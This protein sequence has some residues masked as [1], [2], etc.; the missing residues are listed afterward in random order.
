MP[1]QPTAAAACSSQTAGFREAGT[2]KGVIPP[3]RAGPRRDIVKL[4]YAA[5]S[6]EIRANEFRGRLPCAN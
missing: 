5:S 1:L 3:P 6:G 4:D 2:H